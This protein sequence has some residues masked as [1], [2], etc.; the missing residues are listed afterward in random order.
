MSPEQIYVISFPKSGRTWLRVLLSRY[1]QN[2]LGLDTF[3]LML[4]SA[5]GEDENGGPPFIFTHAKSDPKKKPKSIQLLFDKIRRRN[6]A[7]FSD[8]EIA[9]YEVSKIVYLVR[10]PRDVLV[11]HYW[12]LTRRS[13]LY[14]GSLSEFVR[15]PDFGIERIVKFMNL[16]SERL[17]TTDHILLF[18]EDLQT[19]P[20]QEFARVLAFSGMEIDEKA[21]QESIEFSRFSN[22]R[23][24]EKQGKFGRKLSPKDQN[25]PKSFKVR[26]G[27]VG[28][29]REEMRKEDI[30][31]VNDVLKKKLTQSFIRY[32]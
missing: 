5:E 28:S 7:I 3:E 1:K 11:S 19:D 30:E 21:L 14:K 24:I 32:R 13:K 31:F 22:M 29:F 26:K 8:I 17:D 23:K 20:Y 4:H 25:D 6:P 18:Y 9:P 16:I 10:D 15:D 12:E 27:K 2:I